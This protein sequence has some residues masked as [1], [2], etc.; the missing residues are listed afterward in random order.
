MAFSETLIQGPGI[1][2]QSEREGPLGPGPGGKD[3]SVD[4]RLYAIAVGA[5]TWSS[6]RRARRL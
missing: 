5:A 3:F 4:S 2:H 6:R 1:L